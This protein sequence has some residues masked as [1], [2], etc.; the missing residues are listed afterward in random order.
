[1]GYMRR[2]SSLE[3]RKVFEGEGQDGPKL[4]GG[5]RQGGVCSRTIL[6]HDLNTMPPK[7]DGRWPEQSAGIAL[8]TR[9]YLVQPQAAEGSFH[10]QEVA[11]S[12]GAANVG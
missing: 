1:M 12:W 4:T 9:P 5:A 3:T 8:E 2:Q 6:Q 10:R 7:W 11:Q